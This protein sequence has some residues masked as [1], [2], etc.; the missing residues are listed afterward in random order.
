MKIFEVQL[1]TP[2]GSV[3]Y[4]TL[5]PEV[6]VL[7]KITTLIRMN[8]ISSIGGITISDRGDI[9][10]RYIQTYVHDHSSDEKD[11]P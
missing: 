9:S 5:V 7:E 6:H 4:T 10:D 2:E 3:V 1:K 11:N 8:D